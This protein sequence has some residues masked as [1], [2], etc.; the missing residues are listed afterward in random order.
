M[1]G[2]DLGGSTLIKLSN[3]LYKTERPKEFE[4]MTHQDYERMKMEQILNLQ[5]KF[6]RDDV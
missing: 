1:L 2:D 4:E 3:N 5:G 6:Q